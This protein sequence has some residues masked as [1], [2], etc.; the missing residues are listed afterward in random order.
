[1][2]LNL[3]PE[4]SLA[5]QRFTQKKPYFIASA[6][7]FTL[8]VYAIGFFFA[9]VNDQKQ[10]VYQKLKTSL[11]PLDQLKSQ[12]QK[13]DQDLKKVQTQADAHLAWLEQRTYWGRMI[14]QLRKAFRETEEQAA[15]ILQSPNV[16]AGLWIE[17]L[18]P[19]APENYPL[20]GVATASGDDASG[21]GGG[22]ARGGRRG[23]SA[24]TDAG[25]AGVNTILLSCRGVNLNQAV[26]PSANFELASALAQR[27]ATNT[28]FF[29]TNTALSGRLEVED[30]GT[31]GPFFF[32]F[33]LTL[34]LAKPLDL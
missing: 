25:G 10:M 21:G 17:R 19:V 26:K 22:A 31:N 9:R 13:A 16:Q 20:E 5:R 7:C 34:R 24:A 12:L 1:V 6:L 18:A 23:K 2:E 3:M 14:T 8:I 30:K 27:L 4:S 28:Q 29:T 33:E 11:Q 32:T 15:D